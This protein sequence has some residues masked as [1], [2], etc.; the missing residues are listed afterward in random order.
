M[1]PKTER[2]G[3]ISLIMGFSFFVHIICRD[4]YPSSPIHVPCTGQRRYNGYGIAQDHLAGAR[5]ALVTADD[6]IRSWTMK[7]IGNILT[8]YVL[9]LTASKSFAVISTCLGPRTVTCLFMQDYQS[10]VQESWYVDTAC[11]STFPISSTKWLVA[12]LYFDQDHGSKVR[13]SLDMLFVMWPSEHGFHVGL[14]EKKDRPTA[15]AG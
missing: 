3:F 1:A 5:R 15:C 6:R 14:F 12:D 7:D 9:G 11:S 10:W 4:R 8:I 13:F 2:T